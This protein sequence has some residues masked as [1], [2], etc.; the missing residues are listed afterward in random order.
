MH[1]WKL[2]RKSGGNGSYPLMLASPMQPSMEEADPNSHLQ[3][4]DVPSVFL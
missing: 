3:V 2:V 1:A 4:A